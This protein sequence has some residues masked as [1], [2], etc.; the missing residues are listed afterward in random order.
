MHGTQRD[1]PMAGPRVRIH[2]EF[3]KAARLSCTSPNCVIPPAT[4]SVRSSAWADI[5]GR[6]RYHLVGSGPF[7]QKCQATMRLFFW[8]CAMAMVSTLRAPTSF[9]AE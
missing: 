5:S 1:W 4:K 3:A 6:F 9:N 8:P 2:Q 7:H